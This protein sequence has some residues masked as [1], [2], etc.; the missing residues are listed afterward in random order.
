MGTPLDQIQVVHTED[1]GQEVL[2]PN[3]VYGVLPTGL[4]TC[5]VLPGDP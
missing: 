4:F 5:V 2:L 3:C 1:S